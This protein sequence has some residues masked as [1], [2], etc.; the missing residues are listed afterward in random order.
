MSSP[1]SSWRHYHQ[2]LE[3]S[4]DVFCPARSRDHRAKPGMFSLVYRNS[5]PEAPCS[6]KVTS[7]QRRLQKVATVRLSGLWGFGRGLCGRLSDC[8][9]HLLVQTVCR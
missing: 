6:V 2:H 8:W 4:R 5:D 7:A 9:Q 3:I 1:V